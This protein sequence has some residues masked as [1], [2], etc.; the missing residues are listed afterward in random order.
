MKLGKSWLIWSC[1][2]CFF[3]YQFFLRVSPSVMVD[4]LITDFGLTASSVGLMSSMFFYGYVAMQAP[5]GSMLDTWGPRKLLVAASALIGIA[6]MVFSQSDNLIIASI[7]RLMMGALGAVGFLSCMKLATIWFPPQKIS[8]VIGSTLFLGTFGAVLGGK[9]M[10]YMVDTLGWRETMWIT[11]LVAFAMAIMLWIVIRDNPPKKLEEKIAEYHDHLDKQPSI[12][13]GFKLILTKPQTWF[14]ALYGI[15]MYI[16]LSSFADMWGVP[17]LMTAFKLSRQDAATA[18]SVLYLGVGIGT[19]LFALFSDKIKQKKTPLYLAAFFA[20][21]SFLPILLMPDLNMY[22]IYTLMFLFG[23]SMGGQFIAYSV[24]CDIN[25]VEVSGSANAV[26]NMI[27]LTSGII[28][29][30]VVGLV[31]ET[32]WNGEKQS[33]LLMFSASDFQVALS[34]IPIG[35]LA[36][37]IVGL[38]FIKETYPK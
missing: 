15:L 10:A 28:F 22:S 16:P 25:P 1:A 38:K 33:E 26:Q 24:V 19:P 11:S 8:L 14:L 27:C 12:I 6:C 7:A 20:L 18:T 4:E 9:P 36:A 34:I 30:P 13:D 23:L 3:L 5:V 37:T 2:A 31:L 17:Y 32:V 35:L 29:Q 21:I